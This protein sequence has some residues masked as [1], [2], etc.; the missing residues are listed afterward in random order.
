MSVTCDI[1]VLPYLYFF[2][3]FLNL[4]QEVLFLCYVRLCS[5]CVGVDE[6]QDILVELIQGCISLVQTIHIPQVTR[7][8]WVRWNNKHRGPYRK[9]QT[10]L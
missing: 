1:F 2:F 10:Y 6:A 8:H 7:K 4:F 5:R 3:F 9:R